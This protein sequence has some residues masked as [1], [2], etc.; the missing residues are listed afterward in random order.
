MSHARLPDRPSLEY[1][2]RQAGNRLQDLR[3]TDAR[4]KLSDALLS[5]AREYGFSSWRALK[6][7]I[8]RRQ[9]AGTADFFSACRRG[10]R[11]E[12]ARLLDISESNLNQAIS[13]SDM[14]LGVST[15]PVDVPPSVL[16]NSKTSCLPP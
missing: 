13:K 9:H 2:K 14:N 3:R 5:V 4:A 11:A 8:E 7:E 16:L 10:D 15:L 6:A 12:V 1:L